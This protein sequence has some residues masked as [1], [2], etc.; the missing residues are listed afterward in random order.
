MPFGE[1]ITYWDSKHHL[2]VQQ[3]YQNLKIELLD[4]KIYPITLD[5]YDQIH[6][7]ATMFLIEDC[8]KQ[9]V[10]LREHDWMKRYR[11]LENSQITVDHLIALFSYTNL[12]KLRSKFIDQGY[13]HYYNHESI[14]KI[15]LMEKH[16]EIW[17]WSR[18]LLECVHCYGNPFDEYWRYYHGINCKLLF[19]RFNI[20]ID[21]P[22]S[23]TLD[24]DFAY[25]FSSSQVQVL[26]LFLFV[27]FVNNDYK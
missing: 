17:N 18:L 14:S 25:T 13:R 10:A 12:S 24:K 15:E 21:V 22:S 5:L 27:S 19:D 8:G 6:Y 11:I 2:F 20:M 26:Y 1:S 23:L 7:Y 4:N 9:T 16:K 3:K